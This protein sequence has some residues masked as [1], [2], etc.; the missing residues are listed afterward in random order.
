MKITQNLE[1]ISK[2]IVLILGSIFVNLGSSENLQNSVKSKNYPTAH[3]RNNIENL[4]DLTLQHGRYVGVFLLYYLCIHQKLEIRLIMCTFIII[5]GICMIG[6]KFCNK[7]LFPFSL[8]RFAMGITNIQILLLYQAVNWLNEDFTILVLFLIIFIE[9]NSKL[10]NVYIENE[11]KLNI[12]ISG[13][14]ISGAALAISFFFYLDLFNPETEDQVKLFRAYKAEIEDY[15]RAEEEALVN[16]DLILEIENDYNE[17]ENLDRKILIPDLV[18]NLQANLNQFIDQ[19]QQRVQ[20]DSGHY[21][22]KNF[23]IK[24]K[25]LM[26]ALFLLL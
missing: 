6:T 15:Y 14:F 19:T 26:T 3:A 11:I 7:G 18:N 1:T 2:L 25:K 24:F 16:E 10:I 23:I 12:S 22:S 8:L 9:S 5:F 21:E 4:H 13:L 17:N 20:T